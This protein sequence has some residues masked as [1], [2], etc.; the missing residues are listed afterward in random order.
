MTTT[1][2]LLPARFTAAWMCRKRHRWASRRLR[3]PSRRAAFFDSFCVRAVGRTF[4]PLRRALRIERIALRTEF[5]LQTTYVSPRALL[6]SAD[7]S[8]RAFGT[9]PPAAGVTL[10]SGAGLGQYE[11]RSTWATA[12]PVTRA[13]RAVMVART[14]NR[15]RGVM[16]GETYLLRAR[17]CADCALRCRNS[18]NRNSVRGAAHVVEPRELEEGD[19][20]GVPAV[21]AADAEAELRLG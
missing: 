19:R 9:L 8:P 14:M 6:L 10:R 3:R 12:T 5:D 18:R 13:S 11:L 1:R 4:Q 16:G 21:L 20:V 7:A 17:W 15:R 2:S